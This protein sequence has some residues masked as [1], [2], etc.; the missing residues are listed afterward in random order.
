[1]KELKAP[2]GCPEKSCWSPRLYAI[3]ERRSQLKVESEW[4]PSAA[5]APS[6]TS[7]GVSYM[8]WFCCCARAK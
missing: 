6:E 7:G 3:S 4:P 2:S 8:R 1:M 5:A